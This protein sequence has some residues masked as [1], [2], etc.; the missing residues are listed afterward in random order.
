MTD[1]GAQL[2]SASTVQEPINQSVQESTFKGKGF[3]NSDGVSSYANSV[4]QCLLLSPA[5]R[6]A[7][8]QGTSTALKDICATYTSMADCK[9][10]CLQLQQER[11]MD[12]I[13]KMLLHFYKP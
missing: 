8:Q 9:L 6:Q 3:V 11:M 13:L 12:R 4:M 5:V 1:Y 7:M 10:D 2:R